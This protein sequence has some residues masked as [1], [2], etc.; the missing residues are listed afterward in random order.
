MNQQPQ[1]SS[2]IVWLVRILTFVAVAM[3]VTTTAI[4][5]WTLGHTRRER[6]EITARQKKLDD[7]AR[8]LREYAEESRTEILNALE[9]TA[10]WQLQPDPAVRRFAAFVRSQLS[11]PV[12]LDVRKTFVALMSPSDRLTDIAERANAWRQRYEPSRWT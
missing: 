8:Q 3:V 12:S 11:E 9:E 2:R 5:G 6:S 1:K 10:S 4:E 7:A